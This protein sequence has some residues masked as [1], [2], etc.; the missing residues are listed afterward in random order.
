MES[1]V[2]CYKPFYRC[3]KWHEDLIQRTNPKFCVNLCSVHFSTLAPFRGLNLD[4]NG[5]FTSFRAIKFRFTCR[6]TSGDH[7]LDHLQVL[8]VARRINPSRY[9]KSLEDSSVCSLKFLQFSGGE[10]PSDEIRAP[11][12][13]ENMK[14]IRVFTVHVDASGFRTFLAI[15][16][17][18]P[19]K[20]N[21]LS[22][23]R[24]NNVDIIF[25]TIRRCWK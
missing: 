22:A 5:G 20:W 2:L 23:V 11:F 13:W 17:P 14:E 24:M 19:C 12:E 15:L 25:W 16:A 4:K 10:Q 6:M 3:L 1:G 21:L 18:F 9:W 7:I 8:E